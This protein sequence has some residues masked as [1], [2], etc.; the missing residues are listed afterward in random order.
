MKALLRL[1]IAGY[2]RFLSPLKRPCCRFV[3]TCSQYAAE[4]VDRHGAARG[5]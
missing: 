2:Q 1:A 3:P 5:T 4:A